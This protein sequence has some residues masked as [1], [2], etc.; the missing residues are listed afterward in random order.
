MD[1][2]SHGRSKDYFVESITTPIIFNATL[3][4]SWND[5]I[6]GRCKDN[7]TVA[8]GAY[9]PTRLAQV[10]GVGE[11]RHMLD[12]SVRSILLHCVTSGT[13]YYQFEDLKME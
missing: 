11:T 5:Y 9:T 10:E 1:I 2:C 12:Q 3:C 6:K 13:S 8:M 4:Y 7:P